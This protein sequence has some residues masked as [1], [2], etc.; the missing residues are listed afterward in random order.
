MFLLHSEDGS[1]DWSLWG[2]SRPHPPATAL[3][4]PAR[5]HPSIYLLLPLHQGQGPTGLTPHMCYPEPTLG[6]PEPGWLQA[7]SG[8]TDLP[9][10][11]LGQGRLQRKLTGSRP[12][13]HRVSG[14]F[15]KPVC[16]V[17]STQGNSQQTR[18]QE[19]S[20]LQQYPGDQQ[21]GPCPLAPICTEPTTL[22][23]GAANQAALPSPH[24]A[25]V[26]ALGT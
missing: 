13:G 18:H 26:P 21:G 20:P 6:V 23:L 15:R 4:P 12:R 5:A 24:R 9:T 10:S 14:F 3:G 7:S 25:T 19:Q 11:V 17:A 22:L 2:W 8:T 1:L 16:Y